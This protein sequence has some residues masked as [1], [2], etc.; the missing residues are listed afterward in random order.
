MIWHCDFSETRHLT[1]R[2]QCANLQDF[3]VGHGHSHKNKNPDSTTGSWTCFKTEDSSNLQDYLLYG[4]KH[5]DQI[6]SKGG[7]G[8]QITGTVEMH[9]LSGIS[10][11]GLFIVFHK[12]MILKRKCEAK[13][14]RPK[15]SIVSRWL[16]SGENADNTE[17][18][19]MI[20]SE[21]KYK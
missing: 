5:I 21:N 10:Q 16:T 4:T 17:K 19:K 1:W 18:C 20:K 14:N 13:G 11:M 9:Q 8:T 12:C 2:S 3:S 7:I 15:C 6:C